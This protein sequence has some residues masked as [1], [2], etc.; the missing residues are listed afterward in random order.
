MDGSAQFYQGE[1]RP[2]EATLSAAAGTLTLSSA[3][4]TLRAVGSAVPVPG[5]WPQ[6]ASL[7]TP[8]PAAVV[9]ASY[10]LDTANPDGHGAAALAAGEYVGTFA[11]VDS[12]GNKYAVDVGVWVSAP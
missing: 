10:E 4:L 11:I 2:I 9:T 6:T 5:T 12:S 1:K 7:P 3:T 8:G